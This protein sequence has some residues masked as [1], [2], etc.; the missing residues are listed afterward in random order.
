M[1]DSDS[2]VPIISNL[3]SENQS[4]SESESDGSDTKNEIPANKQNPPNN[5][6]KETEFEI[7]W[8]D[9]YEKALMI[10]DVEER[11]EV[12]RNLARDFENKSC[13]Y[14]NLII[15]TKNL[16]NQSNLGGN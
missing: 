12:L 16:I 13:L 1:F 6:D 5:F 7:D 8:Q 4:D 9:L 15:H 2:Y 11:L 14:A 3:N 10:E